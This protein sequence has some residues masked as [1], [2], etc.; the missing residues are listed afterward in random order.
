MKLIRIELFGSLRVTCEGRPVTT[1][2][3]NRLQ[4]LL[5][6]LALHTEVPREQVAYLL[7]PD[8]SESQ[9]RTNLRQLL[10]HLRRA[11]PDGCCPLVSDNYT[12]QWRRDDCSVDVLEFDAALQ[13]AADARESSDAGRERAALD[14]ASRIYQD[15]LLPGLYDEWLLAKRD[16]YRRQMA[17][18]LERLSLL[19]EHQGDYLSAILHAERLLA[20]DPL[21]ESHHQMLIRL[22]ADR[23]DRAS[24]LRAYHQCMRVLRR[25]LGVE[26]S[27][28]T[29][30]LF[31]RVLK[32]APPE[33]PAPD[34]PKAAPAIAP[35]IIGRGKERETLFGCWRSASTQGPMMAVISGEPG[36][37]K[38]RLAG[39]IFEWCVREG[40]AA[41]QTRC[42]SGQGQVAYAPIAEWLRAP[43]LERVRSLLAQPQLAE[44]ARVLPEILERNPALGRPQPLTESWERLHFYD[45][46]NTAFGRAD[47][48]LLLWIDDLQWCDADSLEWLQSLIC[49]RAAARILI[50]GTLRAEEAAHDH[51]VRRLL[52]ALRRAEQL[53]E[54]ALEPLDAADTL[55]LAE[56]IGGGARPHAIGDLHRA[57][58]GNPLF[59]V[60][61]VRAGLDNPAEAPR[62]HAVIT[63]RL[64]QLSKP[65]FELAGLASAVGRPFSF[66]LLAKAT[67][68]DEESV[69]AALDELWQRRIIESRGQSEYDF[70]HDRLREVAYGDQSLV[71]RRFL[72]RRIARALAETY[73]DDSGAIS[74]QLAAHYEA[75]GMME[76]AIQ[77]YRSAA[78]FDRQRFAD[79]EAVVLLRRAL[80]LNRN[81]PET[82]AQRER[83]LDLL[84]ALGPVLVTTQGYAMPEVGQTYQRALD[85]ARQ[86]QNPHIFHVLSGGW[87][88]H[89]VSGALERSLELSRE[90]LERAD[91]TEVPAL[92]MAG[93][94]VL[95][96]SL[97]HLERLQESREHMEAALALYRPGAEPVLAFFAGPDIGVFCRSYLAH[98]AW[99]GGALDEAHWR[100][101]EAV[102]AAREVAHPFSRAIVL[103][104]AA[105][106]HVFR[107]DHR[108]AQ[109]WAEEAVSL[110]SEYQFAYYLAIAEIIAGWAMAMQG[111]MEQGIP[112]LRH[113]L[114]HF[115][116]AG[117]QLRLPFY[118]GLLAQAYGRAGSTNEALA[119][120]ANA[121]A[122]GNKTGE[123]WSDSRLYCIQG[124]LL[125]STGREEAARESFRKGVE[126]ARR[127]GSRSFEQQARARLGESR[128]ASAPFS[129]RS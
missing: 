64:A 6:Y 109:E 43:A 46:L 18:A 73:S 21:S 38:S 80:D 13:E 39:E 105:I 95:G 61:S 78:L 122:F 120:I 51:P 35:S 28:E 79:A 118:M 27:A 83:E 124:D 69:A 90:L 89:T 101:E 16:H 34:R 88:F 112:R 59:I 104:Y 113:G 49:S 99:H 41:A 74:G 31:D 114:E 68:W 91:R 10:H 47:K 8:S 116:T 9:A 72:H 123:H 40:V 54:I 96:I 125:R 14:S 52:S 5:A 7:W 97:F 60:E 92:R 36:I 75:A 87:V 29:R 82:A 37:G 17:Y 55:A 62:I 106:L 44:L 98:L 2:N 32:S 70:T 50:L 1:V 57:T 45:S 84:V 76:E 100:L 111:L 20:L 94:S 63:A 25:E 11:L 108:T 107:D 121:F 19:S 65:S 126:A 30:A 24:A 67:D 110:C 129:E 115:R 93:H 56:Q 33:T 128:T 22:H 71:R 53:V 127:T 81:L 86:L 3:T 117:A 12:V 85:L 48:P 102:A 66:D 15:D 4:S 58:G 42:Y 77:Q 23:H 26:P 103:D 119:S